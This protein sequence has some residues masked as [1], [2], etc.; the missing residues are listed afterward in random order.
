M[1]SEVAIFIRVQW[2]LILRAILCKN[3]TVFRHFGSGGHK[4]FSPFDIWCDNIPKT[5]CRSIF[6]QISKFRK[7]EGP[8]VLTW[9]PMKPIRRV[10]NRN[11]RRNNDS[12]QLVFIITCKYK[13]NNVHF[14]KSQILE[15][16]AGPTGP[17]EIL[18][19]LMKNE[20]FYSHFLTKYR[21]HSIFYGQVAIFGVFFST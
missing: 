3:Q 18:T 21:G 4:F 14:R 19:N 16:W 1:K 8:K 9:P 7:F 15:I 17:L 20:I 13:Q 5:R 2:L 6:P 12:K 11:F 10:F